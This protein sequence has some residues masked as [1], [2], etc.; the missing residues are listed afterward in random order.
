M[1]TTQN[2][3]GAACISESIEVAKLTSD[4]Y[5]PTLF[6]SLGVSDVALYT[7]IYGLVKG[8]SPSQILT[9]RSDRLIHLLPLDRRPI[10]TSSTVAHLRRRLCLVLALSRHL[11]PL[12]PRSH[13]GVYVVAEEGW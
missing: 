8:N 4:Y 3:S 6:K 5:S 13:W 2:W 10:R 1:F 9:N 7:G 11:Q 12:D